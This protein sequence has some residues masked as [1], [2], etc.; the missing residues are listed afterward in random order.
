MNPTE[1]PA[2]KLTATAANAA[3]YAG[4]GVLTY[5]GIFAPIVGIVRFWGIAVVIP[6]VFASLFGPAVGGIGAAIGIFLSDMIIHG[7]ALLSLTVGVPANLVMFSVIGFLSNKKL[8]PKM[9]ISFT[10]FLATILYVLMWVVGMQMADIIAVISVTAITIII[11]ILAYLKW[12]E[13]T[14]FMTSS[15]L[16]NAVGSL[17]VG[18]GVWTYSQF[19]TLPMTMGENLPIMAAVTW[20]TWTFSNQMPFLLVLAPPITK[21]VWR[22]FP[23]LNIIGGKQ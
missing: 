6:A 2:L 13:L 12:R 1:S 7:D 18:F 8:N 23:P 3:L 10:S 21:A 14:S 11:L 5:F 4:L 20:F 17:I 9:W 19:F 16:G 15:V 22:I